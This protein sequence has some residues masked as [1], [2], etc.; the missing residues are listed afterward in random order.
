VRLEMPVRLGRDPRIA[1]AEDS[2]HGARVHA[3]HHEEAGGRVA[4][5]VE[6]DLPDLALTQGG[7]KVTT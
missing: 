1:V 2:L 3:G 4:Q 7:L 6:T 5:V